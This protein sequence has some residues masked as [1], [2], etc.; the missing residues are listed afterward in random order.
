MLCWRP[1]LRQVS[2]PNPPGGHWLSTESGSCGRLGSQRRKWSIDSSPEERRGERTLRL[3]LSHRLV[4]RRV[5][6]RL[7]ADPP[8][9]LM[10]RSLSSLHWPPLDSRNYR[11]PILG[12]IAYN[13]NK[14]SCYPIFH[15]SQNYNPISLFRTTAQSATNSWIKFK[16]SRRPFPIRSVLEITRGKGENI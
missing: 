12:D 4:I 9:D 15:G 1:L 5:N 13:L 8:S 3:N 14:V 16:T 7:M 2:V 6:D 11:F 10:S